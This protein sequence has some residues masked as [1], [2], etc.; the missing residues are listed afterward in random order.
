MPLMSNVGRALSR[1]NTEYPGSPPIVAGTP[2]SSRQ[3]GSSK[4]NAA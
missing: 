3:A 2:V 4:G 1:S